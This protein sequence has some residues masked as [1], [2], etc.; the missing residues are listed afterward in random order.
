[1]FLAYHPTDPKTFYISAPILGA[2]SLVGLYETNDGAESFT[3]KLVGWSLIKLGVSNSN[4]AV[5]YAT[6]E[7]GNIVKSENAGVYWY[8]VGQND[9][10]QQLVV[11]EKTSSGNRET[12]KPFGNAI[13]AIEVDPADSKTVYIRSKKG[14]LKSVDGG[15]TWCVL[16]LGPG[17]TTAVNSLVIDPDSPN[18]LFAGTWA[19]FY[20][21]TDKG[22]SWKQIQVQERIKK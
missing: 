8:H 4:P 9:E 16:N 17:I 7:Y 14:I 21:S 13:Y 3:V 20:K 10:I 19:G 22:N 11:L 18:L 5:M 2:R 15:A 12:I 6:D 1:M